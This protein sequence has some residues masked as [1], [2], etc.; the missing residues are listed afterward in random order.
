MTSTTN[1]QKSLSR[2]RDSL[3]AFTLLAV[4]AFG[5]WGCS[6]DDAFPEPTGEPV[7]MNISTRALNVGTDDQQIN[8][9]R[10]LLA[11]RTNAG[12]T[13]DCNI[14]VDSPADP[15]VIKALAGN[16]DVFVVANEQ[17]D[18][19]ELPALQNVRTL[20]QLKTLA[21]PFSPADRTFTNIPMFGEVEMVTITAPASGESS[22]TNLA[23]IDV[24]GTDHGTTLPVT[25]V[26][27][28]CK[29]DLKL[30]HSNGTLKEV[31][32]ANL[33]DAIP[34]FADHHYSPA[35]RPEK[36][37]TATTET[38]THTNEVDDITY[39]LHD[40]TKQDILLPSWIF[41]DPT[42]SD[43]AVKLTAV[44]TTGTGKNEKDTEFS[45]LIGHSLPSPAES[46]TPADY[47]LR[48]N[49][50]Y[51]LD[52][53]ILNN[54]LTIS[55]VVVSWIPEDLNIED[56]RPVVPTPVPTP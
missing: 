25:L 44:L 52:A 33:P 35:T 55:A 28:A 11:N 26:R 31:R 27:M 12:R 43:E 50:A 9:V 42:D 40:K 21:I 46:T 41:A 5:V 38:F 48:R 54:T 56:D 36:T 15:L 24:N 37:V 3:S 2:L 14:F 39:P 10:I 29:L 16:F 1:K 47:T 6:K 19:T 32:F 53:R 51:T 30:R 23:A 49:H 45:S 17:P 18:G 8:T 22:S 13:I 7:L 4:I 34:L 20:N